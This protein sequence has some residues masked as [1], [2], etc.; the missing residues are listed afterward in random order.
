MAKRIVVNLG[1]LVAIFRSADMETAY[2][3]RHSD[4]AGYSCS[5]PDWRLRKRCF[6][7]TEAG[8]RGLGKKAEP[9]LPPASLEGEIRRVIDAALESSGVPAAPERGLPR[10][11][12][13]LVSAVAAWAAGRVVQTD[14]S[15]SGALPERA[16]IILDDEE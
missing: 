13:A 8:A 5:C 15:S 3:V 7:A 2:Y 10:L 16:I 1:T 12:E 11:R 14:G 9:K 6:H 4:E